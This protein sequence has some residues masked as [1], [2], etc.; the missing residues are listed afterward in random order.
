MHNI[1]VTL[2]RYRANTEHFDSIW[3]QPTEHIRLTFLDHFDCF[4]QFSDL[5]EFLFSRNVSFR[6][7]YIFSC[8]TNTSSGW[9]HVVSISRVFTDEI[10]ALRCFANSHASKYALGNILSHTRALD[11]SISCCETIKLQ[12][13]FSLFFQRAV[14]NYWCHGFVLIALQYGLHLW[15]YAPL[16]SLGIGEGPFMAASDSFEIKIEVRV[17]FPSLYGSYQWNYVTRRP[18]YRVYC[19]KQCDLHAHWQAHS[20]SLTTHSIASDGPSAEATK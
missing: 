11:H 20:R 15:N 12:H 6:L 8:A 16:Y 9:H 5:K 17:D 19:I 18:I 14:G 10:V 7:K 3:F 1:W 4:D 2:F 13:K